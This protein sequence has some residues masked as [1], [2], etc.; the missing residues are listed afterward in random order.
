MELEKELKSLKEG[1]EGKTKEEIKLAIESFESKTKTLV[2]DLIKESNEKIAAEYKEAIKVVQDHADKLDLKLQQGN[3]KQEQ[4]LKPI[5]QAIADA[6]EEKADEIAKVSRGDNYV[7]KVVGTMTTANNLTGDPVATYN[8]RQGTLPAQ[9]I[10]FRDL[11]PTVQSSTG[12]YVTYRET[13]GEGSFDFQTTEGA[14]KSQLD[15]DFTEVKLVNNFLAGTVDFSRQMIT[16]LPWMQTGLNR[17]LQRDFFKKE[18]DYFYNKMLTSATGPNTT[19]YTVA[20]EQLVDLLMKFKDT[21]YMPSYVVM[22]NATFST[23]ALT[24][25]MDYSVPFILGYN[26]VSGQVE[27]DGIPVIR[28]SWATTGKVLIFDADYV[29][30]VEVVGMNLR[31]SDQNKDNFEKNLITARLECQEELNI[32]LPT[33]I[34]NGS[35]T[36][37][38]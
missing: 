34:V 11:V 31:F 12:L 9:A 15:Y 21:N 3:K 24:K 7:I 14:K 13:G 22:N 35:L 2:N 23:L 25:P 30:R 5:G 18:N 38:T 28:A 17:M 37:T 10:N 19:A 33:A 32:L 6:M 27:I 1:L 20:V 16:N 4:K 26:P 36:V 29:E 8:N